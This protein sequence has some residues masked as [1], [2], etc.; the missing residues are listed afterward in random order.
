MGS[1]Y[2]VK[3]HIR[4]NYYWY[5]QT[6][7]R[8]GSKVKCHCI[9]VGP[10]N[11]IA[12]PPA[13]RG[14]ASKPKGSMNGGM[15]KENKMQEHIQR[16]S[17]PLDLHENHTFSNTCPVCMN[18]REHAS[19]VNATMTPNKDSDLETG[20]R[21]YGCIPGLNKMPPEL[22]DTL[23]RVVQLAI[24][25]PQYEM[26][27]AHLLHPTN[28]LFSSFGQLLTFSRKLT[29]RENIN[30]DHAAELFTIL[31]VNADELQHEFSSELTERE[32]R[33]M[34]IG[35]IDKSI[36]EKGYYEQPAERKQ[37][38]CKETGSHTYFITGKKKEIDGELLTELQC[39][40]CGTIKYD[41]IIRKASD[42]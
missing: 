18:G 10:V 33:Q 37:P 16:F 17:D 8:E 42:A 24:K 29:S 32:L 9:Y 11:K 2:L 5:Y 39:G 38:F 1:Y 14:L 23:Y 36:A 40:W 3:K 4:N 28:G 21:L 27:V 34:D 20:A 26:F 31:H 22:R 25:Q 41:S 19:S 6:T 35:N 7:W 30:G 12:R 13:R 15:K